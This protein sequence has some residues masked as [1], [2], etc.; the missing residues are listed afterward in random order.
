M[1]L[2]LAAPFAALMIVA[3]AFAQMKCSNVF[4]QETSV[5]LMMNDLALFFLKEIEGQ[6]DGPR[7]VRAYAVMKEKFRQI[8][9]LKPSM[10]EDFLARVETLRH[11]EEDLLHSKRET[12]KKEQ[13]EFVTQW[14]RA[15]EH[16]LA[17]KVGPF[18]DSTQ[19]LT[20]RDGTLAIYDYKKKEITWKADVSHK[21]QIYPETLL[22]W[23]APLKKVLMI[24]TE[25][26]GIFDITR[27]THVTRSVPGMTSVSSSEKFAVSPDGQ[28]LI[29]AVDFRSAMVFRLPTLDVAQTEH[30]NGGI[31]K[32]QVSPDGRYALLGSRYADHVVIDLT[33]NSRIE[34]HHAP[35]GEEHHP[36]FTPDSK[37]ILLNDEKGHLKIFDLTSRALSDFKTGML[38]QEPIIQSKGG[39]YMVFRERFLNSPG[40]EPVFRVLDTITG[41]EVTPDFS[42]ET[43][44]NPFRF[45]LLGDYLTFQEKAY[46]PKNGTS[47]SLYLFNFEHLKLERV[48]LELRQ[49][50]ESGAAEVEQFSPD[51]RSFFIHRYGQPVLEIK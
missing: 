43:I 5:D 8:Q 1:M 23:N 12:L 11:R 47:Y 4:T 35:L 27:G 14:T 22:L 18:I 10:R 46:D 41:K 49:E 7:K 6:P 15:V 45:R 26:I 3:P 38:S 50:L 16:P 24:Q 36:T 29:A 25:Q 39:R 51:G 21:I 19:F 33:S 32:I 42:Q 17:Q 31:R 37:A 20:V 30:V 34:L 13:L 28:F 9:T 40:D 2:L 44:S 48:Q